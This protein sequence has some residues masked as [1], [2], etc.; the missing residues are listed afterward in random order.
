MEQFVAGMAAAGEA[1]EVWLDGQ[2]TL[3]SYWWGFTR[4]VG[5]GLLLRVME[6]ASRETVP[7]VEFSEQEG[8]ELLAW[9]KRQFPEG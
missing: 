5:G 1:P 2:N 6:P 9:L 7:I 8:R 4:A 3:T